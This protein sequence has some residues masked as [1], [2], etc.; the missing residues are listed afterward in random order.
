MKNT[1]ITLPDSELLE[2][3]SQLLMGRSKNADYGLLNLN[4]GFR[5]PLTSLLTYF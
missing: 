2:P 1:K 5:S 3:A 4:H